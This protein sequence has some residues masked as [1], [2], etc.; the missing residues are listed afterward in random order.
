MGLKLML[1]ATF[2]LNTVAENPFNELAKDF[3]FSIA[4]VLS[5]V[6]VAL[7]GGLIVVG[8]KKLLNLA[9]I[10]LSQATD[11]Q[12][13]SLVSTVVVGTNQKIVKKL[14][15]A[16][17]DSK[18]TEEQQEKI[19]STVKDEILLQ[20]TKQELST[21][22]KMYPDFNKYLSHLI[23]STVSNSK[24]KK[25]VE[26]V[27]PEHLAFLEDDDE[28]E[29]FFMEEALKTPAPEME[30]EVTEAHEV[31]HEVHIEQPEAQ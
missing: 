24:E 10:E 16:N 25:Q 12:L 14:K 1:L 17:P 4:G 7:L 30:P 31:E 5:Q 20:L 13:K 28:L 21:L 23:E 15:E 29:E 27:Q 2:A 18:L 6:V 11:A 22:N 19:F 9:K 8:I 3:L 26:L